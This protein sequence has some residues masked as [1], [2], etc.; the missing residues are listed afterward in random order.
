MASTARLGK[1]LAATAE[2]SQATGNDPAKSDEHP[3][4]TQARKKWPADLADHPK[5]WHRLAC[6]AEEGVIGIMAV[7]QSDATSGEAFR[8]EHLKKESGRAVR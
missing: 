3:I 5:D 2:N 4:I 8:Q 7:T 1:Y 6:A